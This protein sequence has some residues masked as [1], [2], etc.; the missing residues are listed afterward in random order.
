MTINNESSALR[1]EK[2]GEKKE[3]ERERERERG[4]NTDL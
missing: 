2:R 1:I 3:T 4:N